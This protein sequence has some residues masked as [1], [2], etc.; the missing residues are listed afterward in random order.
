MSAKTENRFPPGWNKARVQA[1]LE[2]YESQTE[3]EA[4]AEDEAA[5]EA[6]TLM[7]VPPELVLEVE[8][9]IA[10]FEKDREQ[11]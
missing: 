4:I 2:H 7:V 11:D 10:K 1:L 6:G 5:M 8:A 9:L 3:E